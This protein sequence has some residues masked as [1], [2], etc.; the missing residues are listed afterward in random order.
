MPTLYIALEEGFENDVVV[1][2]VDGVERYRREGLLTKLQLG[3]ADQFQTDV[4]YGQSTISVSVPLRNVSGATT[5]D[6][7]GDLH[8]GISLAGN[9]IRFR[10][11]S[12]TFGYV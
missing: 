7:A 9:A 2:T 11:S 12:N 1:A 6:V 5:L 8:V 10:T 3:L 4:Q